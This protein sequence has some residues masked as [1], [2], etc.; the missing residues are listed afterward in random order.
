MYEHL[1]RVAP[2]LTK[3]KGSW[4]SVLEGSTCA[5]S[6]TLENSKKKKKKTTNTQKVQKAKLDFTKCW[7]LFTY[8]L[9]CTYIYSTDSGLGALSSLEDD[10]G[11]WEDVCSL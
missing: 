4:P 2:V 1:T 6:T 7:Q 5:D 9:H 10:L 8:N 11:R 3:G